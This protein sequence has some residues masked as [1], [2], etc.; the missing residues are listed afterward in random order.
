MERG[1]HS[2]IC[3][4]VAVAIAAIIFLALVSAAVISSVEE[5]D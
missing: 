3:A 2:S 5:N 4:A 1:T